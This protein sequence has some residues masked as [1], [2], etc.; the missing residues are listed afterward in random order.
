[1]ISPDAFKAYGPIL[2][3]FAAA[4]ETKVDAVITEL[5]GIRMALD[6]LAR[7]AERRDDE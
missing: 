3:I 7:A 2:K 5:R 4:V 1:M 6:R